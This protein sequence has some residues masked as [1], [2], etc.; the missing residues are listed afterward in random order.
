MQAGRL[1]LQINQ[2]RIEGRSI[3]WRAKELANCT[4]ASRYGLVADGDHGEDGIVSS[5]RVLRRRA[6]RAGV[7]SPVPQTSRAS[8]IAMMKP[9]G[10][11][12]G[13]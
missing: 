3:A 9:I 2:S 6:R 11:I 8:K 5:Q 7:S 13:G 12:E 1:Y 10:A 4:L